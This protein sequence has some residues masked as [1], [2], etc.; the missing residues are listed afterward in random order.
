MSAVLFTP[1]QMSPLSS[2]FPPSEAARRSLERL[3]VRLGEAVRH[4]RTQR[5]MTLRELADRAGISI[6][7]VCLVESGR[8]SRL[9]TYARL[10]TAL[11]LRLDVSMLDPRR[12]PAGGHS[13][14]L[15]HAAM[16]ELEAARL[17]RFG[18]RVSLDE[19]YQHYQF[20]GRVDVLAW[21]VERRALLHLENRTRFPNIQEALGSFNAKRAFLGGSVSTR[22]GIAQ[23]RTE[24]HVLVVA[25]TAE[26]LHAIRL[27]EATFRSTGTDG[28]VGFAAW[29]SGAPPEVGIRSEVVVLDPA[30]ATNRRAHWID[31]DGAILARP[32]HRDYRTLADALRSARS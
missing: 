10:S 24:T 8:P 3:A 2:P 29:W 14:D 26:A 17:R 9:E 5:R 22:L 13:V 23:W 30:P 16:G 21:S 12:R 31:L 18:L 28:V 32:R 25:W 7:T 15:V 27:H 19:P 20:A 4:E 6:A 1:F 11:A